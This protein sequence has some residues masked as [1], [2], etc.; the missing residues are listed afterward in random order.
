MRPSIL[1]PVIPLVVISCKTDCVNYL[2]ALFTALTIT[3]TSSTS[4]A[5]VN[6]AFVQIQSPQSTTPI[7]CNQA[8]GTTCEIRGYAGTY[9]LEIGAPGFQSVQRTQIV[10][11]NT[12]DCGC[13]T[14]DAKHIDVALVPVP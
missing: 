7:P 4:G 1:F 3:V 6:G 2:C 10:S 5:S 9:V 14:V 12:P 11:G 8:P 13:P